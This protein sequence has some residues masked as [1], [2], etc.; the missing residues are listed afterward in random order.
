[1]VWRE[2]MLLS[3]ENSKSDCLADLETARG[4]GILFE[5]SIGFLV[6]VSRLTDY[7]GNVKFTSLET[8]YSEI[9]CQPIL[10]CK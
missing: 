3:Y 5:N 7:S 8:F 4:P 1:M 6:Q 2:T 10:I 9:D